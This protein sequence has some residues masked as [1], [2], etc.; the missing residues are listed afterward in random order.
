MLKAGADL[1]VCVTELST[2]LLVQASQGEGMQELFA[3]LASN[4]TPQQVDAVALDLAAGTH[5]KFGE[6]SETLSKNDII[7]IGIRRKG[8][9]IVNPGRSFDLANSDE[10]LLLSSTRPKSISYP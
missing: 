1:A 7:L 2:L 10:L 4:R 5:V 9:H 3:D 6:L 8:E